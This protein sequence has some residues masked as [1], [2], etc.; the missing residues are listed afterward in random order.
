[1]VLRTAAEWDSVWQVVNR[2]RV[3]LPAPPAPTVDFTQEMVLL[4]GLG[5]QGSTGW[6][7][8]IDTAVTRRDTLRVII[9]SVAPQCMAGMMITY[10]WDAV[11]VSRTDVVVQFI[12]RPIIDRCE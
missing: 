7:I 8:R 2:N 9:H 11:R 5:R 6:N 1:M 3:Y 10:P 4:V 12:K